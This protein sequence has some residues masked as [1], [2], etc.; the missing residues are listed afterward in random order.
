MRKR[1]K[2]SRAHIAWHKAVLAHAFQAMVNAGYHPVDEPTKRVVSRRLERLEAF[3]VAHY[4][5]GGFP[6]EKVPFDAEDAAALILWSRSH[7]LRLARKLFQL[8]AADLKVKN[9][10]EVLEIAVES[11]NMDWFDYRLS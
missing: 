2:I 6:Y 3:I 10:R 4:G 5:E 1:Q 7:A 9:P 11:F 8:E